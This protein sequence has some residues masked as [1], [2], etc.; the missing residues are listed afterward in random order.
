VSYKGNTEKSLEPTITLLADIVQC[1][2]LKGKNSK[3]S[4]VLRKRI[5]RISGRYL[6]QT[7]DWTLTHAETTK[8]AI[9]GKEDLRA[10]VD[11]CCSKA[12]LL[13]NQEMWRE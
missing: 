4:V 11:H 2:E 6:L 10:F 7:I 8:K 13:F 5:F 1:L 9:K 3:F 12:L